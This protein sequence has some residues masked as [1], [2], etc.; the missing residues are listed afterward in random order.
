MHILEIIPQLKNIQLIPID[1]DTADNDGY[2]TEF[3]QHYERIK[4]ELDRVF[5]DAPILGNA[6]TNENYQSA[7]DY[8]LNMA[9]DE[10]KVKKSHGMFLP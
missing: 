9:D 3:W 2:K 4:K 6:A 8:F 10:Y 1:H 7:L 5:W